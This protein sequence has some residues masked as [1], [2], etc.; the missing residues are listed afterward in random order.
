[1]CV[2]FF[3]FILDIKFVGRTSRGYT[4]ERSHRI[5]HPPSFCGAC[6]HFSREKDSAIPF[7]RRPRSRI[8]CTNDLIIVLHWLSIYVFLGLLLCEIENENCQIGNRPFFDREK[9]FSFR[10][11]KLSYA[12]SK[13]QLGF[14]CGVSG[15]ST[16]GI[17][18]NLNMRVLTHHAAA[19]INRDV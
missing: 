11:Q 10:K 6:L 9:S 4:E 18:R 2:S 12:R 19:F 14:S 5:S 8:L 13:N 17:I 15:I 3:P 7:R 16:V 1:M